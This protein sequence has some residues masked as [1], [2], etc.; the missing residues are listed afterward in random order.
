VFHLIRVLGIPAFR[1]AN[2]IVL[3]AGILSVTEACSGLRYLVP[4]LALGLL[5]GYL[6]Y[7]TF[8]ARLFVVVISAAA[9]VLINVIRVFIV[10]YLGYT[11]D[12]QHP[13]VE[14]HLVLGWYLFAGIVVLLLG[15]DAV[16]HRSDQP[17][18][19]GG[20][21]DNNAILSA[22]C[23]MGNL[24]RLS[25]LAACAVLMSAGPATVYWI[26]HQPTTGSRQVELQ[27]PSGVGRWTGPTESDSDWL[28]EYHG[29]I[30]RKQVYRKDGEQVELYIGYYP[31]QK[32]GQELINDLN[33]IDNP[34]EWRSRNPR[35]SLRRLGDREVLEQELGKSSGVQYLVWYWYGVAGQMTVNPYQ[36]KGL[37]VWGLL[38][39]KP[40]AFVSAVAVNIGADV[41]HARN[42]L[43][44]FL[45]EMDTPI[46]RVMER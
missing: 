16:L 10:V 37:Q 5:Y 12:M 32:Q 39:G 11:T 40:Q 31:A 6:N 19:P 26:N 36:A 25:V 4:G 30:S 15:I 18:E 9:A 28:P 1:Q 8:R 42:L 44:E 38:T 27:M 3:P 41:S 17:V 20:I 22:R 35:G 2:D 43:G 29:A 46:A 24:G 23:N 14:D 33:R 45:E 34:E 13:L 7:A 21:V